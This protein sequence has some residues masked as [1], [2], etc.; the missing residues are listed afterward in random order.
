MLRQIKNLF[1][2]DSSNRYFLF[3]F[4]LAIGV[5]TFF[6]V[7][8]CTC[9]ATGSGPKYTYSTTSSDMVDKKPGASTNPASGS[10]RA[11]SLY[12]QK[13]DGRE[14][15]L[16]GRSQSDLRVNMTY[17]PPKG[18]TGVSFTGGPTPEPGGPPYVFKN[19]SENQEFSVTY[20]LPQQTTDSSF[21]DTLTVSDSIGSSTSTMSQKYGYFINQTGPM[22]GSVKNTT[23]SPDLLALVAVE[24]WTVRHFVDFTGELNQDV[25]EDIITY[26]QSDDAFYLWRVP[27][28]PHPVVGEYGFSITLPVYNEA[29]GVNPKALEATIFASGYELDLPLEVRHDATVW[30][31]THLAIPANENWVALGLKKDALLDCGEV[32]ARSYWSMMLTS[33]FDLSSEPNDCEECSLPSYAC[34]HSAASGSA[35]LARSV[36]EAI[37]KQGMDDNAIISSDETTCI[38]INPILLNTGATW[39]YEPYTATLDLNPG[40]EIL[41]HYWIDNYALE[42]K[43]FDLA[44]TSDLAG[45]AWT[46][47]PES[48][49]DPFAPDLSSTITDGKLNV[50]ASSTK[51]FFMRSVVPVN[52]SGTRSVY[53]TASSAGMDPESW[54]QTTQLII[55]PLPP[56]KEPVNLT[57]RCYLPMIMR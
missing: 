9:G 4:L 23:T 27:V 14:V 24:P 15:Y 34:Y 44:L 3:L 42:A 21:I 33:H 12:Y 13:G 7:L 17:T 40:D 47:H 36:V 51:H 2:L 26:G 32:P 22:D 1:N 54:T 57:I 11:L 55:S 29:G 41:V 16:T 19:I 53:V 10:M 25:C 6:S 30:A 20:Y 46:I 43:T 45:A 38:A 28:P 31:N 56:I 18:A 5:M 52:A 50:P 8:G 49:S 37:L 35:P 48:A 39:F